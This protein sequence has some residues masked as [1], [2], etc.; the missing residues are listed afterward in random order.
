[1]LITSQKE[2]DD[3]LKKLM[4]EDS[5]AIDSEFQWTST[6]HPIPALIQLGT[7]DEYYMID[8]VQLNDFSVLKE[9]LEKPDCTKVF[10]ACTQDIQ[11]FNNMCGAVTQSIY[12]TQIAYAML[13]TD[14]QI[15]YRSLVENITG[16]LLSKGSQRSNWLRR[17][18]SETQLKYAANDVIWLFKCFNSLIDKLDF[19]DRT[20]WH[21]SE[22]NLYTSES[23][24][25][26]TEPK[27]LYKKLRG[28]GRLNRD[29]LSIMREL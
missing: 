3:L 21:Q 16:E 1:V 26:E 19:L 13:S 14:H 11:L 24:H 7:A 22:C 18:L 29:Q 25:K 9:F 12:D 20:T 15:S 27:N 2:A 4:K 5:V 10:H 6:Y 8:P 23:F 28:S 17:P